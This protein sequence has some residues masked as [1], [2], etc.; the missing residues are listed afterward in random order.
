MPGPVV[1]LKELSGE[2][3]KAS[4]VEWIARKVVAWLL[5]AIGVMVM[6]AGLG[7]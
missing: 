6:L 7:A 1:E 3:G 2:A 4:S 5:L